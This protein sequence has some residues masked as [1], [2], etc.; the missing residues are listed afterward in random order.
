MDGRIQTSTKVGS[1]ASYI[2]NRPGGA[3]VI[4]PENLLVWDRK[5]TGRQGSELNIP[6]FR[7]P[8]CR[9]YGKVVE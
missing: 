1:T 3:F 5:R 7:L 9:P 2:N 8:V 6:R 4:G